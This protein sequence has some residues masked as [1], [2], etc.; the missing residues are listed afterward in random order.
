MLNELMTD[1][2]S[3]SLQVFEFD[4][5]TVDAEGRETSRIRNQARCF[6]E[7]LGDG[8]VIEI[9]AIPGGT[10]QMGSPE[11]EAERSD[12]EGPQHLVKV[13]PFFI[14]KYPITQ[15]QWKAVAGL[16]QI[17]RY[18]EPDPS[19]FK[20]DDRPVDEVSWHDAIEFCARLSNFT[21]RDYRLP[22]EAEWE[23]A[24]RAGTNTPFHFGETLCPELAN[25]NSNET[26]GS[27]PKG[28]YRQETTSVGACQV[29]NAF[30][31]YD[32]HGNVWEWCYDHWHDN[33]EDAPDD[34]S[35]W[36]EDDE[37][38][39]RV[40]HGGSW[41]FDPGVCRSAFRT[42]FQPDVKNLFIGLRIVCSSL[43]SNKG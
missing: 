6:P 34:G 3:S 1:G 9:V 37:N 29:A 12:D 38:Q 14:G 10:F 4:V 16:P 42:D 7:D 25:Y 5:V 39:H 11:T 35:A 8:I 21:G 40:L 18:L 33:Y 28:D 24:C 17:E 26:Y 22:S 2:I 19:H 30:G 13:S 43:S 32:M 20:G 41:C 31:L 23:Y 27:G 15:A 36:L